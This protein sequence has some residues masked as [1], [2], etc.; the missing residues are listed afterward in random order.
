[1]ERVERW[2]VQT[3][4]HERRRRAVEIEVVPLD[5][6]ANEAGQR[7]ELDRRRSWS[8]GYRVCAHWQESLTK[9]R[10]ACGRAAASP[11]RRSVHCGRLGSSPHP[12]RAVLPCPMAVRRGRSQTKVDFESVCAFALTLPEVE[13]GTMYGSPAV[14]LRGH[15]LACI[16]IHKSAEPNTLAVRIG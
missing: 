11:Y 14:K 6:R 7:D 16:A 5:R 10:A 12:R 9:I 13:A 4:E 15:L 3:V 8:D 1:C 2:K